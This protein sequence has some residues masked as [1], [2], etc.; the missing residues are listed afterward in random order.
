MLD[1]I[2]LKRLRLLRVEMSDINRCGHMEKCGCLKVCDCARSL[3]TIKTTR[4][5]VR[6]LPLRSPKVLIGIF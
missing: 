1:A 5:G 4:N 2:G 3:T 6:M